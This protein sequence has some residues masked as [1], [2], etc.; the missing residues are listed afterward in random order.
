MTD[1]VKDGATYED[2]IA[3]PDTRV[4]ELV[5]GNLY[6]SPRPALRHASVSS[7]LGAQLNSAF[8]QGTSGPGGWWI[9]DE[10][11]LH[12]NGDVMVPDIAGWKRDRLPAIPD[13][14][15]I[16]L[17]PDWLCEVLSPST[18]R[19][20]QELKLPRYGRAGVSWLWLVDPRDQSVEVYR[21]LEHHFVL[22]ERHSGTTIIA[23]P[24]FEAYPIEL[25]SLWS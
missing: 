16:D 1:R 25:S 8:H 19:F 23:A 3:A 24:P 15:G 18:Q 10:P 17:P 4:A 5:E 13:I 21:A 7:V 20:D 22:L 12:L 9:L 14:V 2:V 6:L 11:E